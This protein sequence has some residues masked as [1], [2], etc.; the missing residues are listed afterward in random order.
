MKNKKKEGDQST[1]SSMFSGELYVHELFDFSWAFGLATVGIAEDSFEEAS[2]AFEQLMLFPSYSAT[3]SDEN[4]HLLYPEGFPKTTQQPLPLLVPP[5]A[6]GVLWEIYELNKEKK[7][8]QT[9]IRDYY[10]LLLAQQRRLYDWRDP[11]ED[12]LITNIHPW[13]TGHPASGSWTSLLQSIS[14]AELP[15]LSSDLRQAYSL[16]EKLNAQD[17][18]SAGFQVQDPLFHAFLC[19]NNMALIK[20]GAALGEDVREVIEWD[21]LSIFSINERLWNPELKRYCPFDLK[22]SRHLPMNIL[23]S[24]LCFFSEPATQDL[25]EESYPQLEA[26]LKKAMR[27]KIQGEDLQPVSIA[28]H[29][30]LLEGLNNY[31]F[32]ELSVLLLQRLGFLLQQAQLNLNKDDH[33]TAFLLRGFQLF[34]NN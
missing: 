11:S 2:S 26:R 17:L 22:Q 18:K 29:L 34:L 9:L 20:I 8:A 6:A 3:G 13:E 12:G 21:E 16:L 7:E 31:G 15:G 10:P 1:V 28:R 24:A 32:D 19:W 4:I 25:A 30:L 33:K 27:T 14:P 5:I 23:D